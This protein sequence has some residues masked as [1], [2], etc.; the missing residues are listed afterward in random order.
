M[1]R[2]NLT[3]VSWLLLIAILAS[4]CPNGSQRAMAAPPVVQL[5]DADQ[6][7]LVSYGGIDW[8]LLDP[9]SGYMLDIG[10][11][12]LRMF[13]PDGTNVFNPNDSNNIAYWLNDETG[14]FLYTL[15]QHSA[16]LTWIK[17][18]DWTTGPHGN[19]SLSSVSNLKIGLLSD[20][21]W[22][23]YKAIN[24]VNRN[25]VGWWLRTSRSVQISF[26]VYDPRPAGIP[27]IL[28]I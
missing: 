10:D 6:G 15:T 22:N 12:G 24:N 7:D 16:N 18:H 17:D 28:T 14:G 11:Q 21:E 26:V 20:E 27:E 13:D 9:S 23:Q 3:Y 8:V 19:E 2:L 4:V 1:K 5:K 25:D